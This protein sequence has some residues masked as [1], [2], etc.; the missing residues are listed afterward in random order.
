MVAEEEG[1]GA[2]LTVME[3]EVA[4]TWPTSHASDFASYGSDLLSCLTNF[5]SYVS[6]H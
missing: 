3:L 6:N 4:A 5:K 1:N 2:N